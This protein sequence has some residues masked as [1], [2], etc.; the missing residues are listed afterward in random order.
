M[1][2]TPQ[3]MHHLMDQWEKKVAGRR[4]RRAGEVGRDRRQW[5]GR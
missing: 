4:P 3:K 1:M 2:V 5:P